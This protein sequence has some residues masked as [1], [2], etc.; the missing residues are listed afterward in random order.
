[1]PRFEVS[2]EVLENADAAT[3]TH[4]IV[5]NIRQYDAQTQ[6]PALLRVRLLGAPPLEQMVWLEPG[7][8]RFSIVC[9]APPADLEFD[10]DD[11]L[12]HRGVELVRLQSSHVSR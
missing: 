6:G 1:V 9:P 7:T 12:L 4:R 8:T 2:Y 11:D 3:S 5:G 10:P